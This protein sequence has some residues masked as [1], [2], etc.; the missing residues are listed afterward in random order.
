MGNVSCP[1]KFVSTKTKETEKYSKEILD[2]CKSRLTNNTI[3][4]MQ[5]LTNKYNTAAG[6]FNIDDYKYILN[7]FSEDEKRNYAEKL[8]NWDFI[9]PLFSQLTGEFLQ[10]PLEPIVYNRNSDLD[11]VK[12]ELEFDLIFKSL[13]QFF[14][15]V[16]I[17]NGRYVPGQTDN[18]GNPIE[19]PQHPESIKKEVSSQQDEKAIDGQ[20]ILNYIFDDQDVQ[21]KLIEEVYNWFVTNSTFSYKDVIND[22]VIYKAVSPFCLDWTDDSNIEWIEDAE[23]IRYTNYAT[24]DQLF[25]MFQDEPGWKQIDQQ[26]RGG[27]VGG[28]G[29]HAQWMRN[30][31]GLRDT[32]PFPQNSQSIFIKYEH[33]QYTDYRKVYR[34]YTVDLV[35]NPIFY[36]V[37]EDYLPNVNEGIE[38]R[39]VRQTWEGYIIADKH[40][41]QVRPIDHQR[42]KFS[43]PDACKKSYNGSIFKKQ[44]PEIKTIVE[45]LIDYQQTYNTTKFRL[46]ATINKYKGSLALLPIGLFQFW[47]KKQSIMDIEGQ[48]KVIETIDPKKDAIAEGMYYAEA[49]NILF[50]D[51]QMEGLERII[52]MIKVLD[53]GLGTYIKDMLEICSFIKAEAEELVGFNRFRKANISAQDAVTNVNS[54]Q[55]AGSLITEEYFF[56]FNKFIE[57]E[58]QGLIDIAK[59]AYRNGKKASYMRSD[60]GLQILDVDPGSIQESEYGIFVKNG[61]K[62]KE[63][64]DTLKQLGLTLA[65]NG[66]KGSVVARAIDADDNMEKIIQRI[67]I[68]ERELEEQQRI[69]QEQTN[70]IQQERNAILQQ[71]IDDQLGLKKYEIDQNNQ[72]KIDLELMKLS[73][74]AISVND[75]N[76]LN[77]IGLLIKENRAE[78][79]ARF[80][81]RVKQ[82]ELS[83]KSKELE[84]KNKDIDLKEKIS[85]D[86]KYIAKINKN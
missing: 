47:A 31:Y 4:K 61:G 21:M 15:N 30:Y 52:N 57:K 70:A 76:A 25:E 36:D 13:Q 48:E 83:L 67:E 63:K 59:Y 53:F 82:I 42:A 72:T 74:S 5:D 54:G 66:M 37:D 1:N 19:E 17:N 49:T 18:E 81:Q 68:A 8:R 45:K 56:Q 33:Y 40:Y 3:N 65:Q 6:H 77:E 41:I 39:W 20:H 73:Q 32:S 46:H 29:F 14:I 69:Q 11:S 60:I 12:N 71:Q 9:S 27:D 2:Y 22:E 23:V 51:E 86:Q 38:E 55:Y 58:C 24:V 16:L 34:I 35:G 50:V 80:A 7:P 62:T 64:L 79:D 84:L 75:T 43:H 26:L 44:H 78:M 28:G 10:R 85:E